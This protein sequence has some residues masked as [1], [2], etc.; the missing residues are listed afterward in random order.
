[1]YYFIVLIVFIINFKSISNYYM[2]AL[3]LKTIAILYVNESHQ[4]LIKPIIYENSI[5]RNIN[6]Y[7]YA[8]P[9]IFNFY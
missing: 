3:S 6:I 5:L 7:F 1:M 2:K 8:S 4:V 9:I